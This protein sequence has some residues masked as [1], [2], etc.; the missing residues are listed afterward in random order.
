MSKSQ[1]EPGLDLPPRADS[2]L[3][4]HIGFVNLVFTVL[5]YNGPMVVF[6]GFI[7]VAILLGNG[8]GTPAM[9]LLCGVVAALFAAGLVAMG[10]RLPKPGG[11]YTYA[12]AGLGK[13]VGLGTGYAAIICYYSA[14]ISAYALGGVASQ[15]LV[16]DV[17]AGPDLPWW[18]YGGVM[19]IIV[20]I[21]GYLNIDFS[22]RILTVFLALELALMLAYDIS[23]IAKGGAHGLGLDSFQPQNFFSGSISIAFLFG[24]GLYG[25]F[26]ATVIF[27][28]EVKRPEKTVPRAT[29]AVVA[30]LAILYSL[31]AW[32]FINS[33][34]A[35]AIIDVLN[36]NVV[37][38]SSASVQQFTGS[39]AYY[40][41][42]GLLITSS[43]ALAIASH[44]IVSRYL[45]NLGA[46][47]VL[48]KSLGRVHE[49]HGSPYRAS[50]AVSILAAVGIM[51]FAG[52]DGNTAYARLSGIYAF[53][54]TILIVIAALAITVFLARDR[55][56]RRKA[57]WPAIGSGIAFVF[58]AVAL[59]LSTLNFG[60]LTG[61]DGGLTWLLLAVILG[62][63]AAG[64][65][66]AA[67]YR[68][69]RPD[70]YAR[71]GRDDAGEVI[72]EPAN[73][74]QQTDVG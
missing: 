59:V 20:S 49:R 31:T 45:F 8:V 14:N 33:Y 66:M 71:I 60:L 52:I 22:A 46:D 13:I 26:E 63:V 50:V 74:S 10:L 36:Q 37:G 16:R 73:S 67:V 30:I 47:G 27:R 18:L 32:V 72:P 34:G 48:I 42:T 62:I 9:F 6:L 5:A 7:P 41:A 1:S 57:L 69:R 19:Y 28:D 24:I 21:L 56:G 35:H 11:F 58:L 40:A 54:F 17:L 15:S 51:L 61:T 4:G 25:G 12:S 43:F 23:V 68:K 65:V 44:N 39:A 2:H 29:Y 55:T 38:A 53:S 64:M 70:V 3:K